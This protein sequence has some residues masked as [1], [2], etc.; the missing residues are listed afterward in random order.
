MHAAGRV[1]QLRDYIAANR[2][3][4]FF[5]VSWLLPGHP[6]HACIHLFCRD[7]PGFAGGYDVV[8]P[9]FEPLFQV[10]AE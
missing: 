9:V 6:S 2:N 8:D 3:H 10:C 4:F 1:P 7:M 5:V